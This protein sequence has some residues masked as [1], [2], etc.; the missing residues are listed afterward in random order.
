LNEAAQIFF[1]SG[2]VFF[3]VG[4]VILFV[5]LFINV[6]FMSFCCY[7]CI[8]C[9]LQICFVIKPLPASAKVDTSSDG[10]T[11]S[12]IH[13]FTHSHI[14][15]FTHSHIHPFTHSHIH[16]FTHSRIHAFT[17]SRIHAFT[18]SHCVNLIFVPDMYFIYRVHMEF[19]LFLS[20]KKIFS[21]PMV[22]AHFFF[23]NPYLCRIIDSYS[24]LSGIK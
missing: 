9:C 5:I 1:M 3:L 12:H 13:T 20:L 4:F 18:H 22:L 6:N 24:I 8:I 17:H 23:L 11:H 14:H 10:V 21:L 16:T 19:P 2:D 15:P 7:I